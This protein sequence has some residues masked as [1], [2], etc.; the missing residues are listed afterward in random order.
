MNYELGLFWVYSLPQKYISSNI[1]LFRT[2][3]LLRRGRVGPRPQAC[4]PGA[5][6]KPSLEE[7]DSNS[8]QRSRDHQHDQW[9]AIMASAMN[10]KV[11][12]MIMKISMLNSK[13]KAL[14]NMNISRFVLM[15]VEATKLSEIP[16]DWYRC[17]PKNV[18][19]CQTSL[20]AA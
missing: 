9:F 12:V 8:Y 17:L 6:V 14:M 15:I 3:R 10:I 1:P 20:P 5:S 4:Q 18:Q 16:H 2:F 13:K 11:M 7:I 19:K